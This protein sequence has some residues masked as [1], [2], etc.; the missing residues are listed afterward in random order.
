[1]PTAFCNSILISF[2]LSEVIYTVN[3]EYVRPTTYP[4]N[5]PEVDTIWWEQ[6]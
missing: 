3:L 1:M 2:G 4:M 5:G 6:Q